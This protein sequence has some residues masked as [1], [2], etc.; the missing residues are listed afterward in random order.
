MVDFVTHFT[1]L[2][3]VA[4]GTAGITDNAL[5]EAMV[6]MTDLAPTVK[7]CEGVPSRV[8][9]VAMA[10]KAKEVREMT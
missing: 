8:D 7:G 6:A 2:S 9:I 10:K 3:S 4:E 1:V 5:A